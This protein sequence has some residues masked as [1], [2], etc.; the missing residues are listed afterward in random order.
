[1]I[2]HV[3]TTSHLEGINLK[4]LVVHVPVRSAKPGEQILKPRVK[5]IDAPTTKEHA[6]Q[7]DDPKEKAA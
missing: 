7:A 4:D 2:D 6:S 1:M 5:K 3:D